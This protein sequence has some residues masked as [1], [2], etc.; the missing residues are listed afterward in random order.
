MSDIKNK[1]VIRAC[2][3]AFLLNFILFALKLYVGLSS[4]IISIYSD[5]VNNL[6]DSLSGMVSVICFIYAAKSD[7]IGKKAFMSK[8]E[9]LLTLGLSVIVAASGVVFLYNSLER[10]MYPTPMWFTMSFLWML[11]GTAICKLGMLFLFKRQHRKTGSQVLRMMAL[12]CR[13]DFFVNLV[14]IIT[15]IMSK[16]EF[17]A[18]D[19][20]CGIAI[21]VIITAS[22]VKM[23]LGC[24][25]QLVNLPEGDERQEFI[26]LLLQFGIDRENCEVDFHF[27]DEKKAYIK[28][29]VFL[30]DN[31]K[32]SLEKQ[33][34][35]K[36]G[37][38]IYFIK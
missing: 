5:G 26:S 3:I 15:L 17:Y 30:G 21:S 38:N 13:L 14:T 25:R 22:G 16:L 4:N 11:S 6:F 24:V 33:A 36:T 20:F 31:E 10:L 35:E 32:E 34:L 29:S 12:D 9:Q 2:L 8:T 7:G 19:A 27:T 1:A 37:I 18:F 23:L 28:T